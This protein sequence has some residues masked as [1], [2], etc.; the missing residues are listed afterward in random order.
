MQLLFR[1]GGA[2]THPIFIF[3][4]LLQKK[5]LVRLNLRDDEQAD[6]ACVSQRHFHFHHFHVQLSPGGLEAHPEF[7]REA[8][9]IEKQRLH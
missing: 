8:N 1:G 5:S 4:T 9:F 6:E 7:L 2:N 3:Y